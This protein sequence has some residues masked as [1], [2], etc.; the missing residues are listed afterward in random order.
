MILIQ[1]RGS[2]GVFARDLTPWEIV[3][4]ELAIPGVDLSEVL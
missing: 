2:H 3:C 1:K 4:D